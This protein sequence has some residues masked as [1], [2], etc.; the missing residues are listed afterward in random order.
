[1]SFCGNAGLSCNAEV[2]GMAELVRKCIFRHLQEKKSEVE[3]SFFFFKIFFSK[4][5]FVIHVVGLL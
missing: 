1:M 4:Y 5:F 2:E 3:L